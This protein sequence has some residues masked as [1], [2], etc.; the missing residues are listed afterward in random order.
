M[1]L[2]MEL[3]H[4]SVF[5]GQKQKQKQEQKPELEEAEEEGSLAYEYRSPAFS[6][7]DRHVSCPPYF[8]VFAR[9]QLRRAMVMAMATAT[10]LW[11]HHGR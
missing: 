1:P 11:D 3:Y 7:D 4:T 10:F 8:A 5:D 2:T 9:R 6:R